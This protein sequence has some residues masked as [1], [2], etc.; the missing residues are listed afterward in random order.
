M[1]DVIGHRRDNQSINPSINQSIYLSRY[2]TE[3]GKIKRSVKCYHYYH[4]NQAQA[5]A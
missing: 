2:T 5:K 1:S 4:H 3:T